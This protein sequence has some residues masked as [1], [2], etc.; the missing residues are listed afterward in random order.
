MIETRKL[1]FSFA[2]IAVTFFIAYLV[3]MGL[4]FAEHPHPFGQYTGLIVT[5]L[6]FI[7]AFFALLIAKR[8]PTP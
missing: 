6:A 4:L 7:I 1:F 5:A 3:N 2:V 8:K